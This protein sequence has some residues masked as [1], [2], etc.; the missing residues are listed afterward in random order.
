MVIFYFL[1]DL[2]QNMKF[3][4]KLSQNANRIIHIQRKARRALMIKSN[5]M[6]EVRNVLING[7]NALMKGLIMNKT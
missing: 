4:Y 6:I 1:S 7:L 2:A 5:Q 3:T